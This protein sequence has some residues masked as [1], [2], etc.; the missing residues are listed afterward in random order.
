LAILFLLQSSNYVQPLPPAT[1]WMWTL[2]SF[3]QNNMPFN[4]EL[5]KLNRANLLCNRSMPHFL[6]RSKSWTLYPVSW[7]LGLLTPC[8]RTRLLE[9][10]CGSICRNR[11]LLA[12]KRSFRPVSSL[13]IFTRI[14]PTCSYS[15]TPAVTAHY[16]HYCKRMSTKGWFRLQTQLMR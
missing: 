5:C 12:F 9:S 4:V 16:Q 10:I 14:A 15:S 2:L 1:V 8:R 7:K 6:F 3:R 13:V 11:P